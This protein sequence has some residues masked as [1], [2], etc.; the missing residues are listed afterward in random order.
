MFGHPRRAQVCDGVLQQSKLIA[1]RS[2]RTANRDANTVDDLATRKLGQMRQ[3]LTHYPVSPRLTGALD[4]GCLGLD[5]DDVEFLTILQQKGLYRWGIG[6]ADSERPRRFAAGI[7]L[8]THCL[9]LP[10][11]RLPLLAHNRCQ[12]PSGSPG[13]RL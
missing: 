1:T 11:T 4:P 8:L 9:A 12:N 3:H 2:D 10:R 7:R 5:L 6:D 13:S